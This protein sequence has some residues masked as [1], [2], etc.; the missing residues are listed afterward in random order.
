MN[1]SSIVSYFCIDNSAL[2]EKVFHN[3]ICLCPA[4]GQFEYF[5][6]FLKPTISKAFKGIR[7]PELKVSDTSSKEPLLNK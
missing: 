2:L 3:K 4:Y 1:T 5:H 7:K 6:S